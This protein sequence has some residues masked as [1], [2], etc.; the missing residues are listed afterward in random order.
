[1][2]S[3][4]TTTIEPEIAAY[5]YYWQTHDVSLSASVSMWMELKTHCGSFVSNFKQ[6]ID[7]LALT[8]YDLTGQLLECETGSIVMYANPHKNET[9]AFGLSFLH[10][11][12]NKEELFSCNKSIITAAIELL[13][14]KIRTTIELV[15]SNRVLIDLRYGVVSLS[16]P[17][18]VREIHNLRAYT[19]SW[20][21]V[22]DYFHIVEFHRLAR[23]C[24]ASDDTIHF[25][26]TMNWTLDVYGAQVLEYQ[27]SGG[28]DPSNIERLKQIIKD[29][30]LY[31]AEI[32]KT[33]KLESYLL[34]PPIDNAKNTCGYLLASS[35]YDAYMEKFFE[36]STCYGKFP[37]AKLATFDL[38][39][40]S[41]LDRLNSTIHFTFSYD[42]KVDFRESIQT[43]KN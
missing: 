36:L 2:L 40:Y 5:F 1:L 17:Q 23:Q 4:T 15:S 20:S 22:C 8:H 9:L 30:K 7:R 43:L 26:Y 21:N 28:S 6:K 41:V 25:A 31:V 37:R 42:S 10:S 14:S 35:L 33:L 34:A 18:R 16:E 32:Y 11:I 13:Q 27:V 12:P 19:M 38:N 39:M 29:G 3:V 24:S